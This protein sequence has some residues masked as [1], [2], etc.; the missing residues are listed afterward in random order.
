MNNAW[1][2][3]IRTTPFYLDY[4]RYT[5]S[6]TDFVFNESDSLHSDFADKMQS[7][8]REAQRGMEFAQKRQ[9]KYANKKRRELEFEEGEDVLLDSK[10]LTGYQKLGI[11]F[12][13]PCK[14]VSR[15]GPANTN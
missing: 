9:A 8:V 4:D 13:A 2:E 3:S 1:N 7:A 6:P 5:R 12:V 15:G 14:V 10:N 11:A